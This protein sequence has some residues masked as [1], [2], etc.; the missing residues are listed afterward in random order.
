MREE[1]FQEKV[2]P[3][4]K[5]LLEVLESALGHT[6]QVDKLKQTNSV[7]DIIKNI[8]SNTNSTSNLLPSI[9]NATNESFIVN[10]SSIANPSLTSTLKSPLNPPQQIIQTSNIPNSNENSKPSTN[11]ESTVSSIAVESQEILVHSSKNTVKNSLLQ[12]A[13]PFLSL[14]T[15][16]YCLPKSEFIDFGK[17]LNFLFLLSSFQGDVLHDCDSAPLKTLAGRRFSHPVKGTHLISNTSMNSASKVK[18]T[19]EQSAERSF[20]VSQKRIS[21]VQ[22]HLQNFFRINVIVDNSINLLVIVD[23]RKLIEH[24]SQCIEAEFSHRYLHD[25]Q[26]S[27]SHSAPRQSSRPSLVENRISLTTYSSL[28]CG[29]L[30]STAMVALRFDAIISDVLETNATIHVV[31]S[32]HGNHILSQLYP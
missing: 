28:E 2:S 3:P 12:K 17:R 25:L 24:L 26:K 8:N 23:S 16:S 32:F 5:S 1:P 9:N 11:A 13:T 14:K 20:R 4:E 10:S 18:T 29:Q 6:L 27:T 22:E 15:K 21:R 19:T 7:R 31:N 30:Y